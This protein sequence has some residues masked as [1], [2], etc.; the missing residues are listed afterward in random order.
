MKRLIL[1]LTLMLLAA[2]LLFPDAVRQE[3]QEFLANELAEPVRKEIRLYRH[4]TGEIIEL[5]LN[6][7]VTGVVA[8]EMPA[9]FHKEALKA[10]AVCARTYILK[11]IMAGGV[12]NNPHPGADTCDDPRHGQAWLSR[13][14]LKKRWGTWDYYRYY[15]KIKNAVDDTADEVIVYN[16]KLIDPVYHS[17]CGGHTESAGDIWQCDLPYLA[18]VPCPYD[19]DPYPGDK[20]VFT[21]EEVDECLDAGLAAVMVS[22]GDAG[23]LVE[24]TARTASGRPKRVRLGNSEIDATILREALGLRSTNFT[25]QYADGK[26]TFVTKGYGHGVG[27]CQYGADGLAKHGYDYREIL[28][29]YYTGVKITTL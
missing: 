4:A 2:Y 17:S 27:L 26:L 10:Q 5:S 29:H 1:G 21:L 24:I 23:S 28:K 16:G 9:R 6:E 3:Y 15:Y 19:R 12:A 20:K 25:C 22:T 11:R 13:E 8:A 14:E 18:G 7:Y